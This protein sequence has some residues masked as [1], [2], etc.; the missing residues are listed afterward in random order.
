MIESIVLP[1]GKEDA[2]MPARLT[3]HGGEELVLER[4]G[5]LGE[6]TL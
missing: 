5:D 3:L 4:V 1:E 6:L 2:P